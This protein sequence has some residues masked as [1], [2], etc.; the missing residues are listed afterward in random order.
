MPKPSFTE[1]ESKTIWKLIEQAA[2]ASHHDPIRAFR[3]FIT[4]SRCAL[5][6]GRM[7]KEY[8]RNVEQ[9]KNKAD[10]FA[11]AFAIVIDTPEKDLL[12]DVFQGGVT[13]GENGQ[14]FTPDGICN[15]MTRMTPL[16][17]REDR[18]IYV[19]DPACG[20]GRMMLNSVD[21]AIGEGGIPAIVAILNDV[22]SRCV[23][24]AAINMWM[25]CVSSQHSVRAYVTHSNT[26]TLETWRGFYVSKFGGI[27]ELADPESVSKFG[28]V[29]KTGDKPE[30]PKE[31]EPPTQGIL[32]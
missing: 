27:Q 12:G 11:E 2:T 20:S 17:L 23:D 25:K 10:R 9:Y 30:L 31:V 1:P 8:L 29:E 6:F 19:N 16:E 7:E 21:N 28:L 14:F 24:M 5:S 26:L 13:F 15:L 32:F 4:M 22:D 18:P 3:D